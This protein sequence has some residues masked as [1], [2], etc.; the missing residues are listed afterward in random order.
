[1][2]QHLDVFLWER[3]A[4]SLVAY[5][6]RYTEKACFYFDQ[7]FLGSGWYIA[8][9]RASIHSVTLKSGLPVY[10]EEEKRFGGLPSFIADSLPDHWGNRVFGK[11]AKARHIHTR[12]LSARPPCLYRAQGDGGFGVSAPGCRRDGTAVQG[13]GNGTLQAGAICIKR[14]EELQGRDTP[15]HPDRKS[16]QSG[17]FCRWTQAESHHQP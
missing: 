14:S 16:V 17:D 9:L 6:E 11:W 2:I 7:E 1:M 4:G 5:K 12:D 10:G 3:K 15:G 8:P 13:G